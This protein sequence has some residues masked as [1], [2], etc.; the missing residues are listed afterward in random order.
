MSYVDAINAFELVW[1]PLFG[2]AIAVRSRHAS[3]PWRNLGF[4]TACWLIL[5]GLSD[6]VEL[7]TKAWWNPWWL[8][9]WKATC[10]IALITCAIIRVRWLRNP[11]SAPE[12]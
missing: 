12:T 10:I 9:V 8:L 7:Y 4:T 2:V 11:W 6:A 5:F 1:W 3:R